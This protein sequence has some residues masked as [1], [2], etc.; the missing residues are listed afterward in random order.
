MKKASYTFQQAL[1][2]KALSADFKIKATNLVS[3]MNV[4]WILIKKH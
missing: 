1:V 3:S 4:P 2:E